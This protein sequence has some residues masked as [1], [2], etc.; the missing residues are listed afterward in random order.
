M[1]P[2]H[3]LPRGLPPGTFPPPTLLP[4]HRHRTFDG[5]PSLPEA[6]CRPWKKQ[7]QWSRL[8]VHSGLT[9]M[10]GA[11]GSQGLSCPWCR[12]SKT[13][14]RVS[15]GQDLRHQ[16][17]QPVPPNGSKPLARAALPPRSQP[18]AQTPHMFFSFLPTFGRS[19]VTGQHA[20]SQGSKLDLRGKCGDSQGR[21]CSHLCPQSLLPPI[22]PE[23]RHA[24]PCKQA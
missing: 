8:Q 10:F 6:H 20:A 1:A 16:H 18:G 23:Q 11:P 2:L 7:A 21:R 3:L 5:G 12:W 14:V 9:P 4:T 22:F 24:V 15:L 17:A 13:T 19:V